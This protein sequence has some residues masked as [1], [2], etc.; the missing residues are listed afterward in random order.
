MFRFK[1]WLVMALFLFSPKPMYADSPITSTAFSEAYLEIEMVRY[2]KENGTL[3]LQMAQYLSNP[4]HSLD[5]KAALINA[6]SWKFEGKRNRDLYFNYLSIAYSRPVNDL[7][8]E[9][10][11]ADE[12]FSLGYLT[13]MDDYFHPQKAVPLLEKA[14]VRY[15]NSF[16]AHMILALAK[17][18]D[19]MHDQ[20]KWC[21][22]WRVTEQVLNNKAL[23]VDMRESGIKY[24]VDY[25]VLYQDNC[26]QNK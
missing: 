16:T 22:V 21:E 11:S 25:M 20:K 7:P 8:Y 4:G 18:Q 6:L 14:A 17:A 2:A 19:F 15:H 9:I 24:I 1:S 3:N 23:K 5:K 10:L 13:V 26:P 12:L